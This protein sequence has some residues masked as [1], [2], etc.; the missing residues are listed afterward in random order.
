M[1]KEDKQEEMKG[2]E[3]VSRWPLSTETKQE[4][5]RRTGRGPEELRGKMKVKR[6]GDKRSWNR[7]E[8]KP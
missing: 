1:K 2:G 6:R 7:E 8:E 5:I 3:E 4:G